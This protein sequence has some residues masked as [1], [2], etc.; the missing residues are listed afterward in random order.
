VLLAY[1]RAF[2]AHF[3][4]SQPPACAVESSHDW[5]AIFQLPAFQPFCWSAQII[6]R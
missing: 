5:Y 3:A 4:V 6:A 2:V 1:R